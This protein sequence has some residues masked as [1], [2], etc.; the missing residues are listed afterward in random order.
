[1]ESVS[2]AV[3]LKRN[4]ELTPRDHWLARS[5]TRVKLQAAG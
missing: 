2:D 5:G 1:M 4:V 3:L